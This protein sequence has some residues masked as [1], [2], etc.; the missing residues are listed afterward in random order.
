LSSFTGS[1]GGSA[2]SKGLALLGYDGTYMRLLKTTSD[3]KL[4]TVLG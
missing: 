3:G 4:L 1:P 2:P